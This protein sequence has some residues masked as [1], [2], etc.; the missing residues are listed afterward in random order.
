M[1]PIHDHEYTVTYR[2]TWLSPGLLTLSYH[3]RLVLLTTALLIVL[4]GAIG[5]ANNLRENGTS[6]LSPHNAAGMLNMNYMLLP[7]G[8]RVGDAASCFVL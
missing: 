1:P 6:H 3:R 2:S 8:E 7:R 4:N 5:T